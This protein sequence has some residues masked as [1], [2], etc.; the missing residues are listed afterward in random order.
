MVKVVFKLNSSSLLMTELMLNRLVPYLKVSG[1]TWR[2]ALLPVL[3]LKYLRPFELF[4]TNVISSAV[5][6]VCLTFWNNP[7]NKLKYSP[8]EKRLDIVRQSDSAI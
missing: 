7:R 5:M 8:N 3:Q 6:I 2:F 1:F 4:T